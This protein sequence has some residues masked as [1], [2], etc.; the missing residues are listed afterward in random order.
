MNPVTKS[1]PAAAH[2]AAHGHKLIRLEPAGSGHVQFIF[3]DPEAEKAIQDYF[4]GGQVQARSFYEGSPRHPRRYQSHQAR[5]RD[6]NGADFDDDPF[7]TLAETFSS[8]VER[9]SRS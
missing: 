7:G 2:A 4:N 1:M 5:R 8:K 9:N 6:M 3:D